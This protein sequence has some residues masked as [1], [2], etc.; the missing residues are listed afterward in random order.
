ME[1]KLK[2]ILHTSPMG[3]ILIT[4]IDHS[5]RLNAINRRQTQ[6]EHSLKNLRKQ[7]QEN[8][9]ERMVNIFY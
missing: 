3:G 4:E 1:T 9:T 6:I 8:I 7:F 5:K 2:N